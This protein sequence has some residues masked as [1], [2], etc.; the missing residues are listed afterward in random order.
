MNYFVPSI[1]RA[2]ECEK[3]QK[4]NILEILYGTIDMISKNIFLFQFLWV[5]NFLS[6]SFCILY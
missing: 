6:I 1:D 5:I 2:T 3:L 4:Q